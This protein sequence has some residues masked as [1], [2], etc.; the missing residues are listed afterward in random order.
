MGIG[1]LTCRRVA[2]ELTSATLVLTACSG[3]H[4]SSV[5]PEN[6]SGKPLD[7]E[8]PEPTCTVIRN[9]RRRHD[10]VVGGR[11][12]Y[13]L[14]DSYVVRDYLLAKGPENQRISR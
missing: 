3:H 12:P 13:R 1:R 6:L 7:R 9:Y 11:S 10:D 8:S 5:L 4:H 2:L 14:G